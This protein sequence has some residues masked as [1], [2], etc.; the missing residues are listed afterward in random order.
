[1]DIIFLYLID[2]E[3]EKKTVIIQDNSVNLWIQNT[4]SYE[5]ESQK[6][7]KHSS[8][9]SCPLVTVTKSI[10]LLLSLATQSS[11][12]KI[13]NEQ[14]SDIKNNYEEFQFM[15]EGVKYG[16]HYYPQLLLILHHQY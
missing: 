2:S 7:L 4:S 10:T 16:G 12:S 1:M 11:I 3:R 13:L 8:S 15:A 5:Q 6:D 9:F 14:I